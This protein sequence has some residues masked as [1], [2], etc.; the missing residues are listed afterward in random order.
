MGGGGGRKKKRGREPV[1]GLDISL[2]VRRCERGHALGGN[3]FFSCRSFQKEDRALVELE[4][5]EVMLGREV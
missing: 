5:F 2:I 4:C 1:V 3:S